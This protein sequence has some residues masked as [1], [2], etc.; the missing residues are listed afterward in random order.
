MNE[1]VYIILLAGD[2][3]NDGNELG[4][5][6][7][8][9]CAKAAQIF[10]QENVTGRNVKIINSAGCLLF[11]YPNQKLPLSI[12]MFEYL[13]ETLGLEDYSFLVDHLS[14][15]S[16]AEIK[17]G[18]DIIN[19]YRESYSHRRGHVN[20]YYRITIVSSW[21]H[22][23]RLKFLWWKYGSKN[24][25]N[26][27]FAAAGWRPSVRSLIREVGAWIGALTGCRGPRWSRQ[28]NGQIKPKVA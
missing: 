22:L 27:Q 19:N 8:I 11:K 4:D 28:P 20:D 9:R 15:N 10:N 7:K 17:L 12:L 23:P 5:E 26:P 14:L 21:Y 16:A 6:S 2:Q 24:M 13:T 18:M 1:D 3:K 25:P